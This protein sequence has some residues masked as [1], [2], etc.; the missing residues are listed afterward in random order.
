M[1]MVTRPI[2]LTMLSARAAAA[3]VLGVIE[4]PV[5]SGLGGPIVEVEPWDDGWIVRHGRRDGHTV[6]TGLTCPWGV[7]GDG[8][9]VRERWAHW[10]GWEGLFV[11]RATCDVWPGEHWRPSRSMPRAASRT[12][13][14]LVS[15]G[16]REDVGAYSYGWYWV[17]R[18]EKV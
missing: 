17:L 8:L 11:H 13:L 9:W 3:G 5:R 2:G 18:V 14:R 4:R 6:T 16:V 10:D 12:R 1:A 7:T 15:V